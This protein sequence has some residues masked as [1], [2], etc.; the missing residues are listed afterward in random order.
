MAKV[1]V[2]KFVGGKHEATFSF[3]ASILSVASALLPQ[4][5][6]SSLADKGVDVPSILLARKQRIPYTASVNVVEKGVSKT[7][8]VSVV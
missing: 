2:E 5:A 1:M 8:V 6:L 7:V 3:P 4:A